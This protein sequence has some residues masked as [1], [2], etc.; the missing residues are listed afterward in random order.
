MEEMP[1]VKVI[2]S[3]LF[4]V[5]IC[6]IGSEIHAAPIPAP[7]G[8]IYVQDFANVLTKEQKKELLDL[9]LYL[10]KHAD[11]Q[12]VVLTVDSLQGK[13]VEEY[14]LNAFQQYHLGN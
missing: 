9:G 6:L 8:E 3:S 12:I 1:S 10:D 5:I 14:A 7:V 4:F 2:F 13:P 11:T